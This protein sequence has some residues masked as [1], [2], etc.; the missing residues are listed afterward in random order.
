MMLGASVYDVDCLQGEV[1]STVS[2]DSFV[3]ARSTFHGRPSVHPPSERE[4]SSESAAVPPSH[5]QSSTS[6]N[7]RSVLQTR[8]WPSS[9]EYN[10]SPGSGSSPHAVSTYARPDLWS[11]SPNLGAVQ[12]TYSLSHGPAERGQPLYQ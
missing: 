9:P 2:D 1:G 5:G 3:S 6:P 10:N 8:A 7:S 12:H 11:W 4:A